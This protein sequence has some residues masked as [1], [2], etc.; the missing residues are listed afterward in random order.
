MFDGKFEHTVLKELGSSIVL[1]EHLHSVSI[2]EVSS[3]NG[4]DLGGISIP[5]DR[6][7]FVANKLSVLLHKVARCVD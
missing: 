4:E 5:N 1:R 3:Y 6:L 7:V 2:S